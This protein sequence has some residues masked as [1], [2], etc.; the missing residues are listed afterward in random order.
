MTV[1]A[2]LALAIPAHAAKP[3]GKKLPAAVFASFE[4]SYPTAKVKN[5]STEKNDGVLC[6]EVESMDGKTRR[7]LIYS[8]DGA[9]LEI[10]EGM[11]PS[12]LPEPVTLAI[13]KAYPKGVV[14]TAEKL[15]RGSFTGYEVAVRQGKKTHEV[16]LDSEGTIQK[17]PQGKSEKD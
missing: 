8:A 12:D 6:Y 13:S 16:V 15:T 2:V 14:K 7:D 10:E 3:A 17:A 4:K 5:W 11:K 9:V 1:W